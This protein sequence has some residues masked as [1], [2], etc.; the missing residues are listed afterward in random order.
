M[1]IRIHMTCTCCSAHHS[2]IVDFNEYSAWRAGKLIQRAMPSLTP[3]QREQLIGGIC[4][5]CQ[6]GIF[7]TSAEEEQLPFEDCDGNCTGCPHHSDC[8]LEDDVDECGFDPYAGCYTE[9][10]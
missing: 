7:E 9:D 8:Y 10:C 3:T 4:P 1:D 6:E 2:V 5:K